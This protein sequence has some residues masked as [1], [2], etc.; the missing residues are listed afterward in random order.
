MIYAPGTRIFIIPDDFAMDSSGPFAVIEVSEATSR[1][2][3]KRLNQLSL[4][5]AKISVTTPG[6]NPRRQAYLVWGI[7]LSEALSLGTEAALQTIQWIEDGLIISTSCIDGSRQ[8]IEGWAANFVRESE[9]PSNC[10]YVIRLSKDVLE[11]RDFLEVNPQAEA[12]KD[13]FYVGR[14]SRSWEERFDQH[15]RGH[16]ASR[17]VR[18]HGV[19][20]VRELCLGYMPFKDAEVREAEYAAEL[21]AAGY[22]VWQ[23]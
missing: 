20:L 1:T 18:K 15:R 4:R 3:K 22:A 6:T 2:M 13:L 5:K 8:G 10:I 12:A 9:F 23:N 14:T 21:R 11:S 7:A 19:E 17:F 16:K